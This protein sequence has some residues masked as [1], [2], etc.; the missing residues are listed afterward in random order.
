MD[1]V[2]QALLGATIARAGFDRPL[3]TR[4]VVFGAVCAGL[5][6]LDIVLGATDEWATLVHHRGFSHS[7]L[8]LAV[9]APLIGWLGF[10]LAGR[11]STC[12]VWMHLAFWVLVTHALLD[13]CTSYGTQLLWPISGLRF[14]LDAVAVI[15][16]FYSLPLLLALLL[17]QW[18]RIAPPTRRRLAGWALALTTAYLALGLWQSQRAVGSGSAELRGQE[19]RAL[20]VRAAPTLGNIWLWRIVARDERG[21]LRVGFIST[22]SPTPIRF[23]ALNRPEDPLVAAAL[24]SR[25]G[26]T[27]MWFAMDMVS[28]SV[29]RHA[30]GATVYLRDQRY[31]LVTRPKQGLCGMALRFDARGRIVEA[32]RLRGRSSVDATEELAARW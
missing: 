30:D 8:L 26:R 24:Q 12:R 31:G 13:V 10:R 2:T 27:F 25:H 21:D 7:L 20:E 15:D 28:A 9:A 17:G 14:A 32:R 29:E 19:F 23:E 1:T 4:G 18:R 6:D 22:W 5:P 16:P 11:R 3:G